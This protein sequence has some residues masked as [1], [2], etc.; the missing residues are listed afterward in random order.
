MAK[1]RRRPREKPYELYAYVLDYMPTG[2]PSDKHPQHRTRP[3]LQLIGEDYFMLLEASPVHGASFDIGERVYV[4]PDIRLRV[5]VFK[6]DAEIGYEDLTSIAKEVLPQVVETIVRSKEKIFVEFFNIAE[7]ITLRFHSLELLPGIGKRILNR[8]LEQRR[9]K[10]FQSFEDIRERVKIDPVKV[11]VERIIKELQGG[12]KYYL[13]VR[14]PR[15][16]LEQPVKPIYL[17]YLE[18]LYTRLGTRREGGG[19]AETKSGA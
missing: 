11:L 1:P 2:N 5:K 9:V 6:V 13:F 10:P 4:G 15:S 16:E 19:E 18:L 12:E 17:N 7:P 8:I 14:P 3:V